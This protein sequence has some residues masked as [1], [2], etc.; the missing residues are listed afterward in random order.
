MYYFSS[1]ICFKK[2]AINITYFN[3]VMLHHFWFSIFE[4]LTREAT[5]YN[6]LQGRL[7]SI[8]LT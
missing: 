7:K 1:T 2:S 4:V 5:G 3:Y 6:N 8:T